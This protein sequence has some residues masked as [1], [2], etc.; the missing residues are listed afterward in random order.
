VLV[1]LGT[2]TGLAGLVAAAAG[3]ASAVALTDVPAV[4]AQGSHLCKNALINGGLIRRR[5]GAAV[6]VLPLRWG[7]SPA[8]LGDL[9][10]LPAPFGLGAAA[11]ATQEAQ[12]EEARARASERRLL[13]RRR[14]RAGPDV[15]A[16]ADLVYY[17]YGRETPH[18]RLLLQTLRALLDG[19]P[20]GGQEEDEEEEE[21]GR[22]ADGDA[23][24][25]AA[26]DARARPT[27]GPEQQ[28][29]AGAEPHRRRPDA[30]A[31]LAL[32][33]HH[34][35]REVARFLAW[36]EEDFGLR[37]RVAPPAA[38]PPVY[39]TRH[40]LVAEMIVAGPAGGRGR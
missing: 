6:A 26:A 2:G 8:A 1:E 29:E 7:R 11:A 32:S 21:V 13:R 38:L 9:A 36:A 16:G 33:L 20:E 23:A 31:V 25:A 15:V 24:A 18:S 34:N 27:V 10:A 14:R 37:V 39:R 12:G 5:S 22:E 40:V 17:S 19:G 35:P 4:A 28:T 30:L 3:G